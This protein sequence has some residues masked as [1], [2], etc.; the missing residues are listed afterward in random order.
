MSRKEEIQEEANKHWMPQSAHNKIWVDAATWADDTTIQK[1]CEFL[2]MLHDTYVMRMFHTGE[3]PKKEDLIQS[4]KQHIGATDD[5]S[6]KEH[7]LSCLESIID[8]AERMTSGN[9][10][11]HSK[12]IASLAKVVINRLKEGGVL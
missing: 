12:S 5:I 10:M 8:E 4:F 6:L 11:H 2:S 1:G 3:S 9:Y 7:V